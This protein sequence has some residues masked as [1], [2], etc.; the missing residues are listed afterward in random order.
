ML[1][2]IQGARTAQFVPTHAAKNIEVSTVSSY[3]QLPLTELRAN[4]PK[5]KRQV[6]L[7]MKKIAA[8]YHGQVVGFLVPI[9]DLE[10]I[11]E[12]NL[13]EQS[14]DMTLTEFRSEMTECW[15]RLQVDLDCIYITFHS[16]RA[17]A[18][19]SPRL[20]MHLSI[21]VSEVNW[22][23]LVSEF[24]AEEISVDN[25]LTKKVSIA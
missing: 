11:E 19:V 23:L 17:A 21:P 6:Q 1:V 25:P 24:S 18:F 14:I 5:F 10:R 7:G 2:Y 8:T 12:D 20:H 15:E 13:I 22:K 3:K 4:L 16:R 9:K